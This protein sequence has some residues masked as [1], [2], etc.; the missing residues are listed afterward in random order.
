MAR[1]ITTK[2]TS[3]IL[4]IIF[5]FV[6]A[7]LCTICG[8]ATWGHE[9]AYGWS[10]ST[11]LTN[12][13]VT[14]DPGDRYNVGRTS[15]IN[16]YLSIKKPGTY[17]LYGSSTVTVVGIKTGGV[18]VILEDGLNINPGAAAYGGQSAS[19]IN[20]EAKE[21]TVTFVSKPNA[22]IK[23]GGYWGM[24]SINKH[25]PD[26]HIVF[27]TEDP[28][29]PGHI[30]CDRS[31]Y[32]TG[33]AVAIGTQQKSYI[34]VT[35]IHFE[36]GKVTAKGAGNAAGIGSAAGK[37]ESRSVYGIVIDGTAEV[38]A[39]A[40]SGGGPGIGSIYQDTYVTIGGNAKVTATGSKNSPGIGSGGQDAD[41]TGSQVSVSINGGTVTAQGGSDAPGIGSRGANTDISISGGT[42]SAKAGSGAPGI[43]TGS[44]GWGTVR[45]AISG[46]YVT[47][48]GGSS[49]LNPAIGTT[50][51]SCT[52]DIA[53]TGGTV[54]TKS[55]ILGSPKKE[56]YGTSKIII[57]GGSVYPSG[58][59]TQ[60]HAVD[61]NGNSVRPALVSLKGISSGTIPHVTVKGLQGYQFGCEDLQI[62]EGFLSLWIP[63]GSSIESAVASDGSLYTGTIIMGDS[64]L[65]GTLYLDNNIILDGGDIGMTDGS[66]SVSLYSTQITNVTEPTADGYTVEYYLSENQI[67]VANG[68]TYRLMK[69]DDIYV[70]PDTQSW[71]YE[72]HDYPVT[73]YAS[74]KP[75]TY[76]IRFEANVPDDADATQLGGDMPEMGNLTFG[77]EYT[78]TKNAFTLPGYEFVGWSTDPGTSGYVEFDD[79]GT[80]DGDGIVKG[81]DSG[82]YTLY[83]QWAPSL[84][85][86]IGSCESAS[87]VSYDQTTIIDPQTTAPGTNVIITPHPNEGYALFSIEAT[88]G[89]GSPVLLD[90]REDG[91]YSFVMS[92]NAVTI[93]AVFKVVLPFEDLYWSH[94]GYDSIAQAY[95]RELMTGYDSGLYGP[96]DMTTRA[97]AATVIWRL[98]GCPQAQGDLP[99]SDVS[100][101]MWYTD[102]VRW[103]AQAGIVTGYEETDLFGPNDAMTREQIATMLMRFAVSQSIDT[104]ARADLSAFP[105]GEDVCAWARDAVEWAVAENLLRGDDVTGML[106]A[107]DGGTRAVLATLVMRYDALA[108]GGPTA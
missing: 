81:K 4:T 55:G 29:N 56:D 18:T 16:T 86:S 15:H 19:A 13:L 88:D 74:W 87:D 37:F 34:N 95:A 8:I 3:P 76:G 96:D 12:K 72:G 2:Q 105:D 79:E 62:C 30:I 58:W 31:S 6:A 89:E 103:A 39:T 59:I 85:V 108:S 14:L 82:P 91:T 32:K 104:S 17:T 20:V 90:E 7:M 68:E 21:G 10:E 42:V 93:R 80:L 11:T 47:T 70:A 97:M 73:L 65:M 107:H 49:D 83:A 69:G 99:F 50:S 84:S 38:V 78:L 106:A 9:P 60:P 35:N 46:G 24:P 40:G 26:S 5:A 100:D 43:G 52:V 25:E 41:C 92:D 27:K 44:S 94:W 61:P 23:L 28:D 67:I 102:A 63:K 51:T 98:A 75:I 22:T 36:S 66:A 77:K 53:I 33:N 64:S 48:S 54:Y 57:S 45:I 101:G 1:T 71:N